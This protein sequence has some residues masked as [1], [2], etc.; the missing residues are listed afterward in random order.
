MPHDIHIPDDLRDERLDDDRESREGDIKYC[1][2]GT[3]HPQH[4]TAHRI[5]YDFL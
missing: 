5:R 1:D 4:D 2:R 3:K